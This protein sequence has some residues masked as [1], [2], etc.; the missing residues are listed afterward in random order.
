M[1][2]HLA[3]RMIRLR[4]SHLNTT[5][6]MNITRVTDKE[7][8]EEDE[9]S[10]VCTVDLLAHLS[11]FFNY[12]RFCLFLVVFSHFPMHSSEPFLVSYFSVARISHD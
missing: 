6:P 8:E 7:I 4:L 11:I 1:E 10:A 2:Y 3:A 9:Q 12:F 5:V